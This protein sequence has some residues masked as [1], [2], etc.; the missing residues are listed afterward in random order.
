MWIETKLTWLNILSVSIFP[1]ILQNLPNRCPSFQIHTLLICLVVLEYKLQQQFSTQ[2]V[3]VEMMVHNGWGS[4]GSL[5][6]EVQHITMIAPIFGWMICFYIFLVTLGLWDTPHNNMCFFNFFDAKKTNKCTYFWSFW[7]DE[8]QCHWII[9]RVLQGVLITRFM[10]GLFFPRFSFFN[11]CKKR[12]TRSRETFIDQWELNSLDQ[13][14]TDG[15]LHRI[16]G[17]IRSFGLAQKNRFVSGILLRCHVGEYTIHSDSLLYRELFLT[18]CMCGAIP[19]QGFIW[20]ISNFLHVHIYQY[21]RHC[22]RRNTVRLITM[23]YLCKRFMWL[24]WSLV[25]WNPWNVRG[26]TPKWY[27]V[28][29]W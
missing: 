21:H 8:I 28:S 7:T 15:P 2:M 25:L 13:N 12:T 4:K 3:V 16:Y 19:I 27:A 23:E 18:D 11:T 14:L 29:L 5:L 22:W 20:F 1:Q 24:E 6:I 17:F 9:C 10:K 26:I